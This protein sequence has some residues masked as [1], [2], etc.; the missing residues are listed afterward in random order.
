MHIEWIRRTR[1]DGAGWGVDDVPL[2]EAFER[3]RV[4]ILVGGV[5]RRLGDVDHHVRGATTGFTVE[6]M[7]L[8]DLAGSGHIARI[9]I[10]G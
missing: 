10:D 2:G 8:S 9:E 7:Q 6:V 5:E 1:V 4:R 3:Y